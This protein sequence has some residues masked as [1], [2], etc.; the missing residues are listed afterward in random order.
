MVIHD[1]S[2]AAVT[3]A[4]FPRLAFIPSP[5]D[6]AE[7]VQKKLRQFVSSYEAVIS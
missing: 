4:E 2:G 3:A 6:D 7:T 5:T 1:R